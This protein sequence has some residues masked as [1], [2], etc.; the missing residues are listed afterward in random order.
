M[1]KYKYCFQITYY[2]SGS[3][4]KKIYIENP[5]LLSTVRLHTDKYNVSKMV[6]FRATLCIN[7]V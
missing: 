1:F 6:F 3:P 7:V 2:F 4:Q 5:P